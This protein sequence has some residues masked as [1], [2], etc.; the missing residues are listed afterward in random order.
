MRNRGLTIG[1]L[2]VMSL[3]SPAFGR[4]ERVVDKHVTVVGRGRPVVRRRELSWSIED[5]GRVGVQ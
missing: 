3:G 4:V 1:M 5:M 2:F